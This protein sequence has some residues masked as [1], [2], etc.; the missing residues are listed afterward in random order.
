MLK[1]NIGLRY[2]SFQH[3]GDINPLSF[4]QNELK[5][6]TNNHYRHLEPRVSMRYKLD[7]TSSLKASYSENYQYIHLAST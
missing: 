3:S 2:S 6:D 1:L 5:F 4:L 7:A